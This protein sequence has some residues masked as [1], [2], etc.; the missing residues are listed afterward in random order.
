MYIL[1]GISTIFQ[2]LITV[3]FFLIISLSSCVFF[4]KRY[5]T[6]H[7]ELPSFMCPHT[8][9]SEDVLW[10]CNSPSYFHTPLLP[11]LFPQPL[12]IIIL[13]IH[14]LKVLGSSYDKNM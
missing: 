13:I 14:T 8:K 4:F 2:W 7:G 6:V 3:T 12:V 5:V 1:R 9:N 10:M 11:S